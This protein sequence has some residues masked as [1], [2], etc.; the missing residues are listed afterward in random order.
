MQLITSNP[1]PGR[2]AVIDRHPV[3]MIDWNSASHTV[4][5]SDSS[6]IQPTRHSDKESGAKCDTWQWY[7]SEHNTEKTSV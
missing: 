1:E 5:N 4:Y 2:D 7:V 3:R 6:H